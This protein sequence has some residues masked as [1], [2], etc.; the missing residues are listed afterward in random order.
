M[1]HYDVAPMTDNVHHEELAVE[2]N[3]VRNKVP[4][5]LPTLYILYLV[6]LNLSACL[7]L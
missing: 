3:T 6:V 1:G 7:V 2:P 5:K 4:P